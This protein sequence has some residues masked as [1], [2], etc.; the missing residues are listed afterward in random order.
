MTGE[1]FAA[2][3]LSPLFKIVRTGAG[4]AP[5]LSQTPCPQAAVRQTADA[6]GGGDMFLVQAD[7]SVDLLKPD[8]DL[9]VGLQ[10]IGDHRQNVQAAEDDRYRQAE[11]S[12]DGAELARRRLLRFRHLFEN[13]TAGR[14][15]GCARLAQ[16][17][18]ANRADHKLRAETPLQF[19]NPSAD[20]GQR[21]SELA[22]GDGKTAA[23][24]RC[25]QDGHEIE[26]V[27][28]A[29]TFREEGSRK[30]HLFAKSGI[31]TLGTS[32]RTIQLDPK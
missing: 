16:R 10:E 24:D 20:R 14:D 6:H 22:R 30:Y 27:C 26:T 23:I 4:Y 31:L 7:R 25:N 5:D 21:H 8:I 3:R 28:H 1:I 19:R 2:L 29:L 11:P 12:L 13:S 9:R 32:R 15:I 17:K 18:T